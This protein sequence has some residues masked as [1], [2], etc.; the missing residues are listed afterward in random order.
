MNNYF[1][2]NPQRFLS[3][4]DLP[5]QPIDPGILRQNVISILSK[6]NTIPVKMPIM[7]EEVCKGFNHCIQLNQPSSANTIKPTYYEPST[8]IFS[9]KTGSGKSLIGKTFASM[10][11]SKYKSL[12]VVP[13]VDDAIDFCNDINTLSQKP[14]K[15]RCCY[16]ITSQN[17]Q[18]PMRVPI[19]VIDQYDCIV[20]T[21]ALYKILCSNFLDYSFS[22]RDLIVVDERID[23]SKNYIVNEV[24][25]VALINALEGINT[26][27]QAPFTLDKSIS[28]LQDLHTV[29]V[30][31]HNKAK[32]HNV[33]TL[34]IEYEQSPILFKM[35]P[36]TP[37][38]KHS[39]IINE[40]YQ[41]ILLEKAHKSKSKK[42]ITLKFPL[43]N[44]Y[45]FRN[46]LSILQEQK[47][48]VLRF[49]VPL[50]SSQKISMN[51][52]I[53]SIEELIDNIL[54]LQENHIIFHRSGSTGKLIV[55]KQIP[56]SFGTHIVLD[57]TAEVNKLYEDMSFHNDNCFHYQTTD[58][59]IYKNLTINTA[60]GFNQGKSSIYEN[61]APSQ[62]TNEANNYLSLANSLL[63]SNDKMLIIS[64]KE[65]VRYLK[66]NN[67][68]NNI[69][70]THWGNHIGK[71]NWSHCNKVMIIGWNYLPSV[72]H[73]SSLYASSNTVYSAVDN[74]CTNSNLEYSETRLADDLVQ[75]SMRGSARKIIDI[76]GNCRKSEVYLFCPLNKHGSRV[77][78]Y[79]KSQFKDAHINESWQPK[80]TSTQAQRKLTNED[81][82]VNYL[83]TQNLH[84]G[85]TIDFKT[86]QKSL[87]ISETSFSKLPA[88]PRL[89]NYMKAN[90][91]EIQKAGR[92]KYFVKK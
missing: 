62:I 84:V 69:E 64:F 47:R 50:A 78:E 92:R 75:G 26:Y 61:L 76:Q 13:R 20:I 28:A 91:I 9:P 67:T 12:I 6:T 15:A 59:R 45:N 63:S 23:M 24:N 66:S 57:A 87:S 46:M 21:H 73:R 48:Y 18:N 88:K 8:L 10:L 55:K 33:D 22:K 56:Q 79:Y 42:K 53:D 32:S 29:F 65:F 44:S 71:N 7:I 38:K 11:P 31:L 37:I 3:T 83:T 60:Q 41:T 82:V 34:F 43:N 39:I 5:V 1:E 89:S 81:K 49:A 16:T 85:Q 58:P 19:Q 40:D 17:P 2:F 86:I 14:D 36:T 68:N 35:H 77:V 70:F 25:L 4:A 30:Q 80:F 51:H 74:F 90:N 27:T 52:L 54:K 72:E